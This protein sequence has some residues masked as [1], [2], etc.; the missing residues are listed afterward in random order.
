MMKKP[1]DPNGFVK[2][3]VWFWLLVFAVL[4]VL[5]S[6]IFFGIWWFTEPWDACFSVSQ[7]K[8]CL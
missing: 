8:G 3:M 5:L 1:I 2:M 7:W 6:G 4:F